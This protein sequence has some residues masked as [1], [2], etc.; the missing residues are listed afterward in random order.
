[1]TRVTAWA[2]V[3]DP[4]RDRSRMHMDK[5]CAGGDIRAMLAPPAT[6]IRE[7]THPAVISGRPGTMPAK[8]AC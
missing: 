8:G 2:I 7:D 6:G 3:G 4:V 1:M 5:P